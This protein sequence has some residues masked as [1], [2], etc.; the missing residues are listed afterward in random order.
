MFKD[1]I[2]EE[3]RKIRHQIASENQFNL[4]KIFEQ[5]VAVQNKAGGKKVS[6]PFQKSAMGKEIQ[7]PRDSS[8][9]HD[10]V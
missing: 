10:F 5:A 6:T 2:V 4:E 3:V 1:P 7:T 8:T 9:K